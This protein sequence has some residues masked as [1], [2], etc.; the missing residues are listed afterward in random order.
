MAR[1]RM[2]PLHAAA[3]QGHLDTVRHRVEERGA[4]VS[5]LDAVDGWRAL[6]A[7]AACDEDHVAVADPLLDTGAAVDIGGKDATPIRVAP[8]AGVSGRG[9]QRRHIRLG[10]VCWRR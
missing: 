9:P 10:R 2:S 4:H 7:A 1:N 3:Q 5:L 8:E 6:R